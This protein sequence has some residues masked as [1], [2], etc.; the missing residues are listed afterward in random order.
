MT[1]SFIPSLSILNIWTCRGLTA[2]HLTLFFTLRKRLVNSNSSRHSVLNRSEH[3]C[4]FYNFLC[5]IF[6]WKQL[7]CI[8]LDTCK[9]QKNTCTLLINNCSCL[10]FLLPFLGNYSLC[11]HNVCRLLNIMKICYSRQLELKHLKVSS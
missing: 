11:L 6:C 5:I 9:K 7:T 10:N 3:Q 1:S 8:L 4:D 2:L